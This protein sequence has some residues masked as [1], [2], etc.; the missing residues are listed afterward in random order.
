[1][2]R[3]TSKIT[4]F[5]CNSCAVTQVIGGDYPESV[6]DERGWTIDEEILGNQVDLCADCTAELKEFI[7]WEDPICESCR[8]SQQG[9]PWT[10]CTCS[11]ESSVP[12]ES[13][14]ID[15]DL[16]PCC[17]AGINPAD[18]EEICEPCANDNHKGC[19]GPL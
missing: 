12:Q 14:V 9:K 16:I 18:G 2:S 4:T 11:G 3:E 17:C 1:M 6:M 8:N 10:G 19:V 13:P 7:G 15:S 5:K